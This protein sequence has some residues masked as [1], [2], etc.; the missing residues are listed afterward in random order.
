MEAASDVSTWAHNEDAARPCHRLKLR[1]R[2]Y[3]YV[4]IY[5]GRAYMIYPSIW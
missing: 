5:I 1:A 3:I 2:I 4:C